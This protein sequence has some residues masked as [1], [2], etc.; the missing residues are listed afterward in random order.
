MKKFYAL[1]FILTISISS[2]AQQLT[3]LA[4]ED[5]TNIAG[6]TFIDSAAQFTTIDLERY[7]LDGTCTSSP[8]VLKS[9]D[10]YAGT[11][12]MKLIATEINGNYFSTD[13]NLASSLGGVDV[14][15]TSRPVSLRGYYKFTQAGTDSIKFEL[16]TSSSSA[17]TGTATFTSKTST[18]GY[19]YFEAPVVY[20]SQAA[21]A[22]VSLKIILS[23][24]SD[25]ADPNSELFIDAFEFN[26]QPL[27]TSVTSSEEVLNV[28]NTSNEIL[29]SEEVTDINLFTVAGINQMNY[30]NSTKSVSTSSLNT[31]MYILTY[32]YNNK[33]YSKKIFVTK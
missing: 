6:C 23:N 17:K 27:P 21:T 19:Q 26:Y 3:S 24:A 4:F 9:T 5:W 30:K 18:T 29:F 8:C 16:S 10:K 33:Y 14:P 22:S 20:T 28:Y 31:G 32:Q 1:A 15:F 12:A 13:I 11:Y 2:Y 7:R 25:N